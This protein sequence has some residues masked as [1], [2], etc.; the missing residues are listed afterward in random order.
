MPLIVDPEQN[1]IRALERVA[2]WH[3]K[4]VIEIGCGDGRLTLR[5]AGLG[6]R[7]HAFD[8]NAE[9]V[10]TAQENLPGRLKQYISYH[11][12]VVEHLDLTSELFDLAVFAWSL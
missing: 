1:E 5:L 12:A 9:L 3:G 6:A 2:D 8:R 11:V 7:V 10:R 4:K